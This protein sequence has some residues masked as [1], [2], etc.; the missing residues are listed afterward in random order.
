MEHH[1]H[2]KLKNVKKNKKKV[3]YK[4]SKSQNDGKNK[5]LILDEI[6]GILYYKSKIHILIKLLYS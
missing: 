1:F 5:K 2:T 3:N 4:N 6:N